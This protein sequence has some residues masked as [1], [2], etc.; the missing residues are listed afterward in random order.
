MES[1]HSFCISTPLHSDQQAS[2][3]KS[4][5]RHEVSRKKYKTHTLPKPAQDLS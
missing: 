1:N 2:S 3:I 5:K 4:N